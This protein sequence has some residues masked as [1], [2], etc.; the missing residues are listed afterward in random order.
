MNKQQIIKRLESI[1]GKLEKVSDSIW[2]VSAPSM[3]QEYFNT[4]NQ[5]GIF[6]DAICPKP[7][8]GRPAGSGKKTCPVCGK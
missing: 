7:T 6:V 5:V 3:N 1:D 4:L 8:R 2:K